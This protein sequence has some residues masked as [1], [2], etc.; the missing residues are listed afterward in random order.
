MTVA[1][2]RPG[3]HIANVGVHGKP[4]EFALDKLWI[5]N[6]TITTGL[7]NTNTSRMLIKMLAQGK[8]DVSDFISH[9][10]DLDDIINAY[11]T[12]ARAADTKALKVLL[13]AS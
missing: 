5:E 2:V 4:V 13:A 3:G 8:L 11:D 1:V 6:L 9:R 10:F 12:F 7:V